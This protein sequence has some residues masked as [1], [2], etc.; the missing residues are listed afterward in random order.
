MSKPKHTTSTRRS[1][2]TFSPLE[3]LEGVPNG[4]F[5]IVGDNTV[6][7]LEKGDFV[8]FDRDR[9]KPKDGDLT[10]WGEGQD[11][12][13]GYY[14]TD[15]AERDKPVWGI[16]VGLVRRFKK[17][18]KKAPQRG[19]NRELAGLRGKLDRL[20]RVPENEAV[21]FQLE[22]EIHRLEQEP[23]DEWPDVIAA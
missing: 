23:T 9:T 16:A 14:H 15:D 4:H 21:R 20:E 17:R 13:F 19:E 8:L 7:G 5:V 11:L 18:S 2:N 22:T 12:T 1:R 3:L 10:C 6:E